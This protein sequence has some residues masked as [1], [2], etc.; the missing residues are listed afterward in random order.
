MLATFSRQRA[1]WMKQPWA[2]SSRLSC[3]CRTAFSSST[4]LR[5]CDGEVNSSFEYGLRRVSGERK[6]KSLVGLKK[7]CGVFFFKCPEEKSHYSLTSE[8]NWFLYLF[9]LRAGHCHQRALFPPHQTHG[10]YITNY[11]LP[12]FHSNHAEE[13]TTSCGHFD[14]PSFYLQIMAS[15]WSHLFRSSV[16]TAS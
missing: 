1:L 6:K 15:I 10:D 12:G 4:I 14:F 2:S 3:A 9:P 13:A 5:A 8:A 11:I 7:Q 16:W